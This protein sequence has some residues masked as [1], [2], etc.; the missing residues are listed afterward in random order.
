[1]RLVILLM[2]VL[3]L[4]LPL[5]GDCAGSGAHWLPDGLDYYPVPDEFEDF[6]GILLLVESWTASPRY[7]R[8]TP[9]RNSSPSETRS[10]QTTMAASA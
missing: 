10:T 1:M 4:T 5:R 9:S 7:R 3:A 2:L 6:G 8:R